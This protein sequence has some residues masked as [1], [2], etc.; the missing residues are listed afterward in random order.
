MKFKQYI[1]ESKKTSIE[2]ALTL[3]YDNCM[4]F[5]KDLVKGGFKK[6]DDLMYSGRNETNSIIQKNVRKDR[7]PTD[8]K[9]NRHV[10]LDNAFFEKF[11]IKGRSQ[12]LFCT[13]D[14]NTSYNYNTYLIFPI[15]KYQ[16]LWSDKIKDTYKNP[17]VDMVF[18]KNKIEI[19]NIRND[20]YKKTNDIKFANNYIL[21]HKEEYL[22]KLKTDVDK[23]IISTYHLGDVMKAI[24]SKHEIMVYT[25]KYIG[26]KRDEYHHIIR[27]YIAEFGIKY[28]TKENIQ[29]LKL[30]K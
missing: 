6:T 17:Y 28:P 11:K 20:Q 29:N 3:I 2:Y 13:G 4:P 23:Q 24:R 9:I 15:N 16:I 5:I 30:T 8:T 21:T 14:Y 26:L 1:K 7:K 27:S 12:T 19:I 10:F 25:D 22:N 18:D